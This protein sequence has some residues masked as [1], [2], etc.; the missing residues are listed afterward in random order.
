MPNPESESDEFLARRVLVVMPTAR[1]AERTTTLLRENGIDS[2]VCAELGAL[3]RELGRGAGA[4]LLTDEFV[5]GGSS[6]ELAHAL[7]EQPPWSR[8][9]VVVVAHEGASRVKAIAAQWFPSSIVVERPV[10][11]RTLLSVLHSALRARE[12]QY[13]IRDALSALQRSEKELAQQAEQL[14]ATDRRKDEFLATLAHE[15]RNPLAP[16]QTGLDI[17]GNSARD[18]A[19]ERA[20][21]V[22]SRQLKHMV[23]LIDDLLDVSRITQG[24]FELKR[25]RVTLGDVLDAAVETSRPLIERGHHV[26]RVAVDEPSTVFD[27]DATRLAQVVSNLLNN[28]SKYTP[29][30]GAIELSARRDGD[31]C[32]LEVRDN[33]IGIPREQLEDVFHM[34]SQVNR[35]L[36]RS[37]GGMGI[38]LGLAKSLVELHGGSIAVESPGL[39]LGSTFS[40]RLPVA[41]AGEASTPEK[42]ADETPHHD[43]KRVLVVDDNHDAADMLSMMLELADYETRKAHDAASAVVAAKAWRPDVVI[44][45]IGLPDVSGYEVARRLRQD[46]AFS[47][48]ELIA[49]SG[50]GTDDDKRKAFAAGFDRHFTKPVDAGALFTALAQVSAHSRADVTNVR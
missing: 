46:E 7:G 30:G 9:P 28:A 37:Q 17:L 14:R 16:I 5:A 50:W 43:R 2:T 49:L 4:V 36:E 8:V 21:G 22:M 27:A 11:T 3:F 38:G 25:S 10:R 15:L 6:E 31:D 45:D 32:V 19:S 48:T 39:G 1:D 13:Q 29:T 24:K 40:I 35:A 23:R 44:L 26:L 34:F 20:I 41:R 18:E 42:D 12:D 33:G 47:G